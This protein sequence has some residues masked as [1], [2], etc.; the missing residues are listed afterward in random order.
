VTCK[1]GAEKGQRQA[2]QKGA[3]GR[4]P[5]DHQFS[6]L[7]SHSVSEKNAEEREIGENANGG[8]V[9]VERNDAG[10]AAAARET[11]HEEEHGSGK[12]APVSEIRK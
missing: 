11:Y 12:D 7:H 5:G 4:P 10:S 8:G 6:K 3:S 9:R 2:K 1:G